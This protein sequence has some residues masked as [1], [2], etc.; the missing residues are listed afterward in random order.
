MTIIK[1]SKEIFMKLIIDDACY[2]YHKI[3]G[4]FGEITAI[5]GREINANTVRNSDILIVR[6]RTQVNAKLLQGSKIKFV[7]STVAGLEHI[8]LAYLK[9]N[10]IVFFSAQGCNAMAVAEFVICGIVNLANELN[11]DY[12]TKTLGIIG[13]GNV[14]SRLKAKADLMGIKTLLNDPFRQ[15]QHNLYNFVELKAALSADIVTFHTP[16]TF[17]GDHP[18][19]HLLN[20]SNFH[21]INKNTILFNAARGSIIDEKIWQNTQTKANIIDCWENEPHINQTLKNTAY[22][23]T[24]HIAGHSI[25]AKFMGS[26]MV[27][28]ALCSFMNKPQDKLIKNIITSDALKIQKNTLKDTLNA[29]YNFQ[30]DVTAIDNINNFENY[31]RNYPIRYEWHHYQSKIQLPI[32]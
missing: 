16:L 23:A 9:A 27:Y 24:P 8:D 4:S 21:Y 32:V 6:S 19:Y 20:K 17:D 7:G 26:F 30:K 12:R 5:A 15:T 25:D 13:V 28:Q 22:W 2:D 11:F 14:G 18:T 10:N 3:F 29:I 1:V 31:R